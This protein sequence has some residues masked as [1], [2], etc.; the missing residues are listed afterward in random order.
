MKRIDDNTLAAYL[1]GILSDEERER[2]ELAVEENDELKAIVDG[3]ISMADDLYA[4]TK[5]EMEDDRELR[6]EAC[7]NIKTVMEK[8]K[9]ESGYKKMAAGAEYAAMPSKAAMPVM[10]EDG[11]SSLR[12]KWPLYR[13]ILLAASVLAFVSA[14]GIWLLRSP[15]DGLRSAPSFDM[16]MDGDTMTCEPGLDTT[17]V[18][19]I[20]LLPDYSGV[21]K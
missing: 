11:S 19:T 9:L 8:V 20:V 1:E 15:E 10:D 18:D 2:V 12:R 13:R 16:P 14:T 5:Q 3:W 17:N 6:M 4:S 7:R 21:Y